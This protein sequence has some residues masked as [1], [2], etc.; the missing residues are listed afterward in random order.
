MNTDPP[1]TSNGPAPAFS[2]L[3][4]NW[5][6][7]AWIERALSS[8]QLAMRAAGIDGELLVI[9]DASRDESPRLV[10]Q[11]S[12]RAR[13]LRNPHNL[14]FGES[15][16]RGVRAA[17]APVVVLLNNDLV[18]RQDFFQRLLAP[19]SSDSPPGKAGRLFAVSARTLSW[20]G[21]EPN[22]VCMAARFHQGR[23]Q[24]AWSD[25]QHLSRSLFAQGGAMACRRDLFLSLGGFHPLFAPGYWEDY[26]LCWQAAR[27]GFHILYEPRAVAFHVG[28]GSMI[29]RFGRREVYLTRLRN[30]FLFEWLNL[31]DPRLLARH[32]AWLP[33]HLFREWQR[34]EG[35]GT[36]KGFARAC[37]LLPHVL[38]ERAARRRRLAALA[39]AHGGSNRY[40]PQRA[41][42]DSRLL[43]LARG[44]H[45]SAPE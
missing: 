17:R 23:L 3:V 36:T 13:L 34:S 1:P 20:E 5:E 44:F 30:Q 12:P 14:G 24:P 18:V 8:I 15:V 2:V 35:Y 43:A 27:A 38:R 16:N 6:G 39:S 33:R 9:D 7:S 45:L 40:P 11:H 41:P 37:L 25:P 28:G 42:S 22:H 32:L 21:I 31:R 10:A 19:F 4:A 29:R 26:D